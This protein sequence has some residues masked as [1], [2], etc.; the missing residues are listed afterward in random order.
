M[1]PTNP[2]VVSVKYACRIYHDRP[3]DCK[4]YPVSIAE[5]VRDGCGMIEVR[6]LDAPKKAQLMLDRIMA[7]SRPPLSFLS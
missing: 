3:E 1:L 6:D 5:M 7:D 4:H 2:G